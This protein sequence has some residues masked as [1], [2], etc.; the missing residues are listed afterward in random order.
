[1]NLFYLDTA[2]AGL[3]WMKRYYRRNPQLSQKKAVASLMQAENQLMEM[4][5][6]G[7]TFEDYEVRVLPLQGTA[8][9]FLYT[10]ARDA[11]WI[12][13]V[14]DQRGY[15]SGEALRQFSRE[16]GKRVQDIG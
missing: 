3:A 8:F 4:P 13:D 11:V 6:S 9:S 16:L 7:A 10:V 1:M 2:Q 5:F 12:I 14:H 15:R